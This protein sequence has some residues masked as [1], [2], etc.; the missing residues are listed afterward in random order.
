MSQFVAFSTL[1]TIQ[2]FCAGFPNV[3]SYISWF[4]EVDIPGCQLRAS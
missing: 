3:F 4:A 1:A 2:T